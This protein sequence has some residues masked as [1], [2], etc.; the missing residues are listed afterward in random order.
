MLTLQPGIQQVLLSYAGHCTAADGGTP[1]A[2]GGAAA[3]DGDTAAA[4]DGDTTADGDTAADGNTAAA[5]GDTAAADVLVRSRFT[6]FHT[7]ASLVSI[8]CFLSY[9]ILAVPMPDCLGK[10][11]CMS[12]TFPIAVANG[13]CFFPTV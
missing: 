4:A 3:A 11:S 5:D 12:S 10:H 6:S 7:H 1:A 8:F 2:D 9:F 13:T